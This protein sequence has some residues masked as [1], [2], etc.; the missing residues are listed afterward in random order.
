MDPRHRL[1]QRQVKKHLAGLELAPLGPFL[2]AVD[3]AYAD[4]DSAKAIVDRSLELSSSELGEA[5]ESLRG[6]QR[7]LEATLARVQEVQQ[8]LVTQEKL[9]SLGTL[10]AG[11][12]HEIKNPL[13]FVNNFA[14]LM[15]E[16]G[17]ELDELLAQPTPDFRELSE[18][19]AMLRGNAA[20]VLQHG[21][22]ADSIVRSMLL[23]ARGQGAERVEVRWNELVEESSMLAWHGLRARNPQLHVELTRELAPSLPTFLGSPADLSRVVL[24][25]VANACEAA[26]EREQL[27][28]GYQA[29]VWVKTSHVDGWVELR[30]RDN[31]DG[32]PQ[33]ARA[34][35]FEPFF[36]TKPTGSGTG[37]GLSISHE[38]I[39]GGHG[40]EL[41]F[42]SE[43]RQFTEFIV[44]LPTG[45]RA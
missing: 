36:T 41:R 29:H 13:N 7:E 37:L 45:R 44:R 10:T 9:A 31:G 6:K 34:H 2:A 3:E 4:F 11:I 24:N 42:E 23:H 5:N 20:K 28:R 18:V 12:A 30:V 43:E 25:L 19:L 38:I 35:I 8:Q 16:L 15:V 33:S 21:R 32:I 1:L 14:E 22:R 17:A 40:G 26:G 39:V 27:E